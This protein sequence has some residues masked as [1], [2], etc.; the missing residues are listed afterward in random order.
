MTTARILIAEAGEAAARVARTCKR[1][2]AVAITV[3]GDDGETGVHVESCDERV[4]VPGDPL[5]LAPDAIVDAA[6]RAEAT[7]VHPGYASTARLTALAKAFAESPGVLV[8][9]KPSSLE[10]AM[11]RV[12]LRKL[13]EEVDVRFVPGSSAGFEKL[14]DAIEAADAV[15]YPVRV[16]GSVSGVLGSGRIDDEDQLFASWDDLHQMASSRGCAI[17]VEKEIERPR[18]VEVLVATDAHGECLAIADVEIAIAD[19]DGSV[20]LEES[21][22]PELLIKPDGESI[23][24]ALFDVALRLVQPLELVGLSSVLFLLDADD[25]FHVAGVRPGLPRHHG[26]IE[27][28]S[29]IDLVA[30][31]LALIAGEPMPDDV[32]NVQPSG[33]AF[34]ASL[35]TD[36]A[37]SEVVRELRAPPQPHRKVRFD[38]SVI[39][40]AVPAAADGGLLMR[41]CTYGAIRHAAMLG[42]DRMLAE[43]DV[44]PY[45]TNAK[46]LRSVIADESFRAGK[47]DATLGE[48]LRYGRSARAVGAGQGDA[49]K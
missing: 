27:M 42:L 10:R 7:R 43:I 47:Y 37:P 23:R 22:S 5:A 39:D 9:A 31:E 21:P 1:I 8:A 24:L 49:G 36:T 18:R 34:G 44:A 4:V 32:H 11:D 40:G 48:R 20:V 30:I 2:D 17:M 35:R 13:A 46:S 14:A 15:G 12:Q 28:V 19:E 26:T 3:V 16:C 25:R 6:R 29:G 41:V 45:R 38:P 33:H